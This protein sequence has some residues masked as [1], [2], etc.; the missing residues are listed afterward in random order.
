MKNLTV[1][2]PLVIKVKQNMIFIGYLGKREGSSIRH[3]YAGDNLHLSTFQ[4][5]LINYIQVH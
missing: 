2:F 3:Y 5:K 4:F 1:V